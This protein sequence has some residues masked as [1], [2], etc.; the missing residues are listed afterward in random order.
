[1]LDDRLERGA[2]VVGETLR[3]MQPDLDPSD[4]S[5]PVVR[6]LEAA[7]DAQTL[8]RQTVPA[9]VPPR[10]EPDAAREAGDEELGRRGG[11]V[12]TAV[13]HRLVDEQ[14]VP[15]DR[16]AVAIAGFVPNGDVVHRG[17]LLAR[18]EIPLVSCNARVG[19]PH[20][21]EVGRV[22]VFPQDLRR[23]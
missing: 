15:S 19:A 1:V 23:E 8:L 22:T 20:P 18:I 7:V 3:K 16:Q 11:R 10:L 5:G 6:E 9:E 4:A 2:L 21:T 17:R 13:A 14:L 12:I